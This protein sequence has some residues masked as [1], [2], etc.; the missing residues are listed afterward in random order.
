MKSTRDE[1]SRETKP[2]FCPFCH[3]NTQKRKKKSNQIK[4][5]GKIEFPYIILVPPQKVNPLLVD[6]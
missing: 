3:Q 4:N 1:I 2:H 5:H 6:Y